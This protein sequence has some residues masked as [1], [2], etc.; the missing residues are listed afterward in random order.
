[1]R[2]GH[3]A[4]HPSADAKDTIDGVTRMARQCYVL[5]ASFRLSVLV[6]F[7]MADA[8]ARRVTAPLLAGR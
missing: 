8:C 5:T 2:S 1:V 6:V 4:Q 7:V 3:G